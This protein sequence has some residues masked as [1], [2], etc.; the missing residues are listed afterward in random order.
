MLDGNPHTAW[1]FHKGWRDLP[2]GESWGY[3]DTPDASFNHGV[4]AT[5]YI[6][7]DQDTAFV[8]DGIGIINGYAKNG[9]SYRRNN[10]ITQIALHCFG[11]NVHW[12]K[13]YALRETRA[14]QRIPLPHLRLSYF[15][16]NIDAVQTGMDD[17]LCISELVLYHGN[18]PIPWRL[19][20]TVLS[21]PMME[22]DGRPT[23]TLVR[24]H[25]VV[26]LNGHP[27][28]TYSGFPQAHT[29]RVL[30]LAK[31]QLYLYDLR[32]NVC[33]WRRAFT[34]TA[35]RIG[36]QSPTQALLQTV[37]ARKHIYWYRLETRYLTWQRRD[38]PPQKTRGFLNDV[39][40]HGC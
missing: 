17:D 32:R 29:S 33:V 14:L 10:R 22:C 35:E 37:D 31:Q 36:W 25:R 6:S 18:T 39:T 9:D 27:D 40:D 20:P 7:A 16:F 30:L 21:T 24:G 15:S 1:V 12:H 11:P 3:S 19:T 28:T 8:C 34:G 5:I 23:Y 4:G 13:S 26:A 38:A 2:P